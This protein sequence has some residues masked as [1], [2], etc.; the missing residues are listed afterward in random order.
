MM[1]KLVLAL[2]KL[3]RHLVIGVMLF[4]IGLIVLEGWM[5]LIRK[6]YAEYKR[7][8]ETRES[9][10]LA[11]HQHPD[12]ASEMSHLANQLKQLT[13]KLTSE[14]T[15][16]ASDDKVAASFMASLDQSAKVHGVSLFSVK[17]KDQKTVSVFEEMSFEVSAK[18]SYLPLS[19][20]M[21]DFTN[22]L[23]NNATVTEF[24]MKTVE[25]GKQVL[26]T[27]NIALYRPLKLGETTR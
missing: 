26:L 10:A 4:V 14:L 11:L 19:E 23:G 18:G 15:F 6:P 1:N 8:V 9:L 7:I 27:L 2:S 17:P 16:P 21:L 22:T 25:E 24:D 13:D 5:L 20:W 12:Q 3:N